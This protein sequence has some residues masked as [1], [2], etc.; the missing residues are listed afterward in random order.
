MTVMEQLKTLS[1]DRPP[2]KLIQVLL[3]VVQQ[4]GLDLKQG[5]KALRFAEEGVAKARQQNDRDS[6]QYLLELVGAARKQM[7]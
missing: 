3:S 6:E 7:G 5:A 2:P 1:V 4:R